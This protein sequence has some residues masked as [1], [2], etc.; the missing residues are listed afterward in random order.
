MENQLQE[1]LTR[2]TEKKVIFLDVQNL[3]SMVSIF[4][5]LGDTEKGLEVYQRG[6]AL[7]VS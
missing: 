3:F 6:L 7:S 2:E 4:V 5:K 1:I